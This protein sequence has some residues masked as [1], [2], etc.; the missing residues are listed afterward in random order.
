VKV[1]V[2]K[3]VEVVEAVVVGVASETAQQWLKRYSL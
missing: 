3:V 1:E 2:V